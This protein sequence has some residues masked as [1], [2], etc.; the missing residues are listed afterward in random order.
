MTTP[1]AFA[2]AKILACLLTLSLG[3]IVAVGVANHV[4]AASKERCLVIQQMDAKVGK[5]T[6]YIGR[7]HARIDCMNDHCTIVAAAPN[8]DVTL[9]NKDK[10]AVYFKSAQW[11][12]QGLDNVVAS[13][14]HIFNDYKHTKIKYLGKSAIK[15]VRQLDPTYADSSETLYR[16]KVAKG[17][18]ITASSTYIGSSDFAFTPGAASFVEGFYLSP[19]YARV[20]LKAYTPSTSGERVQLDTKSISTKDLDDKFFAVPPGLKKAHSITAVIAGEDINGLL[21][22]ITEDH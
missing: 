1:R 10:Y 14:R 13:K 9:F 2:A 22:E 19:S 8:W 7:D 3:L 5:M 15:V 17:K 18:G 20:M 4:Q 16:G 11:Q 21:L 6:L 12:A